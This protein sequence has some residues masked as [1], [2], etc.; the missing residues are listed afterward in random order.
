MEKELYEHYKAILAAEQAEAEQIEAE[1]RE[2][3]IRLE[4]VRAS[5]TRILAKLSAHDEAAAGARPAAQFVPAAALPTALPDRLKYTG[6]SVRWAILFLMADGGVDALT[7]PQMADA[8][9]GG[10]AR[11]TGQNFSA[12][13]SAVVSE[14]VRKKAELAPGEEPGTYRITTK[15]REVW[16]TIKHSRQFRYGRLGVLSASTAEPE[17]VGGRK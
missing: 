9:I 16:D 1:K 3:D 2:L 17:P 7:T 13:V 15:G 6:M 11:T 10:G 5:I 4:H 8:L 12:N 14:M